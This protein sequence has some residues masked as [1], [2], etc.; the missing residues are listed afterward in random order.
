MDLEV[1]QLAGYF[2]CNYT[3]AH[4]KSCIPSMVVTY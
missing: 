2:R 4:L 1:N 3:R